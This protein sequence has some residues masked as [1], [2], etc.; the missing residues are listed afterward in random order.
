M[1]S[2]PLFQ[3]GYFTTKQAADAG[4]SSQ[5]LLKHLRAGRVARTLRGIYRLAHFPAGEHEELVTA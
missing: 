2:K 4:Y 3:A 1:M 5:L